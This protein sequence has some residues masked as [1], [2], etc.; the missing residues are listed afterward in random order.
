[1]KLSI[2]GFAIAAAVIWGLAMMMVNSANMMFPG[3]GV[4]FLAVVS[5]VYPGYE[6]GL[7][8][9]SIVVGTLYGMVDAAIAA[10]IFAWIYNRFAS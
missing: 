8:V 4:E 6:P 2:K 5:S 3:Y 7:G 9:R 10:I 1:M